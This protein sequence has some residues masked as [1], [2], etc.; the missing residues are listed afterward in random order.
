VSLQG[1]LETIPLPDVLALLAATKKTGELR[2][3]GARGDGRLWLDAGQVVAADVPRAATPVDAVFELLRLAA[4]SFT[5]GDGAPPGAPG[6][7]IAVDALLGEAQQRLAVWQSIE[8]VVPSMACTVRLTPDLGPERVTV[9]RSQWK[10]LVAVAG[11]GDV[12]GVMKSLGIGEFDASRTVRELV[13]AGLVQ[14]GKAPVAPPSVPEQQRP[15]PPAARTEPPRVAS[16][17]T[18]ASSSGSAPSRPAPTAGFVPATVASRTA[19]PAAPGRAPTTAAPAAAANG[20]RSAA[21]R[22]VP[23]T[24][25]DREEAGELVQQ[26]ASLGQSQSKAPSREEPAADTAGEKKGGTAGDDG[27][28]DECN[29]D[30]PINRGMLLKFLSSVRP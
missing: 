9:S 6:R 17:P 11:G 29:G 3:T 2:I 26:L 25:P 13:D 7:P 14:V 23:R 28:T 27:G 20:G 4:G 30:E 1:T 22:P 12:N 21:P 16:A 8:A 5:F 19:A 15:A 10:E 24:V 18:A